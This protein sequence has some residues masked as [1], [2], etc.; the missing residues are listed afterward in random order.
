[1]KNLKI[2]NC[3]FESLGI[4]N[5]PIFNGVHTY[6]YAILYLLELMTPLNKVLVVNEKVSL[7]IY[8]FINYI[9]KEND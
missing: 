2:I 4:R 1:M 9:R 6:I 7:I 8:Q 3:N 5:I